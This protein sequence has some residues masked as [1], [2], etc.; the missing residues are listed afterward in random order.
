M[1]GKGGVASSSL[2]TRASIRMWLSP[3]GLLPSIYTIQYSIGS[4]RF[5]RQGPSGRSH[6]SD[7][8]LDSE[9]AL[10]NWGPLLL[11]ILLSRARSD[12]TGSM[13][14]QRMVRWVPETV[15][16]LPTRYQLLLYSQILQTWLGFLSTSFAPHCKVQHP[17]WVFLFLPSIFPL[18]L[19]LWTRKLAISLLLLNFLKSEG[20]VSQKSKMSNYFIMSSIVLFQYRKMQEDMHC[21]INM[22]T[23][24]SSSN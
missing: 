19:P 12:S 9:S 16:G 22:E 24:P 3:T 17:E 8:V 7:I 6:C 21:G 14:F 20:F 4:S 2:L 10:I 15:S 5:L 1:Q 18:S 23:L 11:I 13:S